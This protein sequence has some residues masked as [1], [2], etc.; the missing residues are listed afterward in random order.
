MTDRK[1]EVKLRLGLDQAK[2]MMAHEAIKIPRCPRALQVCNRGVGN[3]GDP[4]DHMAK[5]GVGLAKA[6]LGR[7]EVFGVSSLLGLT[8]YT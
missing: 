6:G 2:Y 1:T 4:L 3:W 7:G 5:D 8:R